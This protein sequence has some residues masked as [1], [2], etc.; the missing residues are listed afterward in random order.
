MGGEGI[1]KGVEKEREEGIQTHI[2]KQEIEERQRKKERKRMN[3]LCWTKVLNKKWGR[4]KDR[5][6]GEDW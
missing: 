6:G 1:H 5:D 2:D 4:K 3:Q